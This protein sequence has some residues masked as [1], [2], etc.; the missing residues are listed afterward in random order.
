ME[1]IR[2]GEAAVWGRPRN[3]SKDHYSDQMLVLLPGVFVAFQM[4]SFRSMDE[5]I[6]GSLQD[7]AQSKATASLMNGAGAGYHEHLLYRPW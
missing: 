5:G 2:S 7:P 3:R 1:A 6:R 4:A